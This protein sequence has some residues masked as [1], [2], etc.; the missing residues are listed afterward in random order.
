MTDVGTDERRKPG[1]PR[2]FEQ[3]RM[4]A[5]VRVRPKTY[6]V[7]KA[8]S[9]SNRRSVSEEIETDSKNRS[10]GKSSRHSPRYQ[11]RQHEHPEADGGQSHRVTAGRRRGQPDIEERDGIA[12]QGLSAH[13][14]TR[15]ST[16]PQRRDDRARRLTCARQ[17]ARQDA[18][19][20]RKQ[21]RGRRE[22]HVVLIRTTFAADELATRSG[23][24]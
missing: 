8:A 20:Y 17:C 15:E 13:R 18:L 11:R 10:V 12:R 19:H 14:P 9:D 7:L 5:A 2:K 16:N 24:K 23:S 6:A 22:R 1:R 21:W 3:G 4:K